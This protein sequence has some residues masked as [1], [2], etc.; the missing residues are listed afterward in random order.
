MRP[1]VGDAYR[2]CAAELIRYATVIVGASDAQDVVSDA[3]L[4]AFTTENW[5]AVENQRAYLFRAVLNRATSHQRS[6]ARR[7]RREERAFNGETEGAPP[8]ASSIDAHRALARLSR[9]QRAVV[10][11]TY[12]DDLSPAQVSALLEVSEGTVKKQLA[13]AREQLR[14]ILDA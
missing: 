6:S 8:D 9:Q 12:W 11:L 1:D 5:D 10:Y 3:V 14:R 2:A 7:R 4:G 13:R